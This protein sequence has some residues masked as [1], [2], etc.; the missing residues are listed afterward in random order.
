MELLEEKAE[1]ILSNQVNYAKYNSRFLFQNCIRLS[2]LFIKSKRDL[3]K[4]VQ[5]RDRYNNCIEK[6]KNE[7]KNIN[8]NSLVEIDKLKESGQLFENNNNIE[9][10]ELLILL[11]NYRQALQSIQGMNDYES[12]AIIFAN[13]VKINYK[14][15]NNQNYVRLKVM[16]EKSVSLSKSINKNILQSQ[17]YLEINNILQELNEKVNDKIK[18]DQE[19]FENN[20]KTKYK[21]IFDE[22]N[23]NRKKTN[24][25]FIEFILDKH[26][27]K[28]SP[29]KKNKTVKQTWEESP[30]SFVERLSA[31][32]NP[33]NYP[34]NTEE[35]QLN[36]TI[37]HTISTEL[38][39][40]LSELNPNQIDLNE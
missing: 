9:R 7:I 13:I 27:P 34:R 21:H 15:L 20:C 25:E 11:D 22:I 30:I 16:A 10:E 4:N 33:D 32:Y 24:V 8:A 35:E 14:Y 38:N 39:S 40:I 18:N 26:P 6:C 5:I 12:E 36:Y 19:N 31:R 3:S 37:Y 23:E 1:K 17:W 28:K 29:L 2:E